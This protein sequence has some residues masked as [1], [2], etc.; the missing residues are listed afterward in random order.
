MRGYIKMEPD[1][2]GL[3]L[4]DLVD[5]SSALGSESQFWDQF[6]GSGVANIFM[7]L[8]VG[9]YFGIRKLCDRDSKCK[10]HIHCCCIDL[11]VRDRTLRDQPGSADGSGPAAV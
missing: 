10:S 1:A 8:A 6:A 4:G 3:D 7:M 2:A 11:D 5:A 9:L